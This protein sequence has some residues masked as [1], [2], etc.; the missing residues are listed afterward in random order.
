MKNI[1]IVITIRQCTE[2]RDVEVCGACEKEYNPLAL[3][4][5]AGDVIQKAK[6]CGGVLIPWVKEQLYQHFC[7]VFRFETE[8]GKREFLKNL[9]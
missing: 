2:S 9:V 1:S 5:F 3:Y 6:A 4:A 8:E 7:Y